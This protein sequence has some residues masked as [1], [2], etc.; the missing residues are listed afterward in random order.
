MHSVFTDDLGH[1]FITGS[2]YVHIHHIMEGER[3]RSL[4]E[5][6][7]FILP[8]RYDLHN[9]A[10]DSAHIDKN[11]NN[12]LKIMCQNYWLNTGRTKEEWI[13]RY[14]QWWIYDGPLPAWMQKQGGAGA[15]Q[16]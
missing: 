4:S 13:H 12:Q 11:F 15:C 5:E 3:N 16:R 6:D 14:G 2:P 8:L 10:K 7:G 9:L 1:C